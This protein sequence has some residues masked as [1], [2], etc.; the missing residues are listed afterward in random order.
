MN[1]ARPE[2]MIDQS[3]WPSMNMLNMTQQQALKQIDENMLKNFSHLAISPTSPATS[4][5]D[6][7][8]ANN[9][10]K[11]LSEPSS[12][13]RSPPTT[14]S[15]NN[16]MSNPW[17]INNNNNMIS[18]QNNNNNN[19]MPTSLSNGSSQHSRSHTPAPSQSLGVTSGSNNQMSIEDMLMTFSGSNNLNSA[20]SMAQNLT[21]LSKLIAPSSSSANSGGNL[22]H[23]NYALNSNLNELASLSNLNDFTALSVAAAG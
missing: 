10:G 3:Q 11:K 4:L 1:S 23:P 22:H 2:C 7:W 19:K 15:S 9:I 18:S 17:N 16:Q 13:V 12:S 6:E 20:A 21:Q 14:T 8:L 5:N